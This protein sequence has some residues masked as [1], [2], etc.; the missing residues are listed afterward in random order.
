MPALGIKTA[1]REL[2][3]PQVT[4]Y[5]ISNELAPYGLYAVEGHYIN[6]TARAYICDEGSH[7]VPLCS[8]FWPTGEE[9]PARGLSAP[10]TLEA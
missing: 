2:R 3:I 10:V 8:D 6:G 1:V 4:H 5:A 9:P 7:L